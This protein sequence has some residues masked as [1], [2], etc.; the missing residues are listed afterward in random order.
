MKRRRAGIA[1]VALLVVLPGPGRAA[2]TVLH[3]RVGPNESFEISLTTD[4]GRAVTHLDP[5]TYTVEVDDAA[6]VHDFQL[7]GPGVLQATSYTFVGHATWTVTLAD[8]YYT[9][10][11][12]PHRDRMHGEFTV[13][14]APPPTLEATARSGSVSV[15]R[16][17]VETSRLDP[18]TYSIAVADRSTADNVRLSGPGVDENTQTFDEATETWTVALRDGVYTLFSERDAA[19]TRKTVT[20]GTPPAAST[21]RRLTAVTGPDFALT[22]LDANGAPVTRLDAG[23]YD[24]TVLDRSDVHNFDLFG[25]GLSRSTT[26]GFVGTETWRVTLRAGA[27]SFICDPH[28]QVMRGSFRVTAPASPPPRRITATVTPSGRASLSPRR[29]R[30]GTYAIV[31]RDRS[32]RAGFRLRGPGVNRSTGVG[33]RGTVTWR[34]GLRAGLYRFGSGVRL[35]GAL[36]VTT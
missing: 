2:T 13:G 22:L 9:F 20:V 19:A 21:E 8:G 24:V 4:D 17:G 27:Y 28:S 10:F 34:L 7:R 35:S 11:C 1:I 12:S 6:T 25:P 18:G 30:A 15:T 32:A 33:F 29:V 16:A 36:T 3:A 14:T 5:G 31:V 26:P 23:A